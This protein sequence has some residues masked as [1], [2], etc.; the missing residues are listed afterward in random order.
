MR[1]EQQQSQRLPKS[2]VL[3]EAGPVCSAQT[4]IPDGGQHVLGPSTRM[5]VHTH[6]HA[7]AH[8]YTHTTLMPW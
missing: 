1:E 4:S 8:T 3:A 7:R 5:R 2:L 6:V